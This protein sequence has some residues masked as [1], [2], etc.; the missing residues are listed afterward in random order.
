MEGLSQEGDKSPSKPQ[1]PY[2]G[3]YLFHILRGWIG[4]Y[5]TDQVQLLGQDSS[6]VTKWLLKT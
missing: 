6:Y 1:N 5:L 4:L 2:K 3:L